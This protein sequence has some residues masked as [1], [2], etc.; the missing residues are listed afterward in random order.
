MAN[1][2]N[3]SG[4]PD[5]ISITLDTWEIPVT[6]HIFEIPVTVHIFDKPS[7]LP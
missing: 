5:G 6:V 2:S 4:L 7:P 3:G 1:N